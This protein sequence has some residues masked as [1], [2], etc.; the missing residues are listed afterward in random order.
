M[1]NLAQLVNQP[2]TYH[3]VGLLSEKPLAG[4]VDRLLRQLFGDRAKPYAPDW[5]IARQQLEAS[6][7][8]VVSRWHELV[9]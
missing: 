6:S 1:R 9:P 7:V 8:T 2:L 3:F 4:P 5:A